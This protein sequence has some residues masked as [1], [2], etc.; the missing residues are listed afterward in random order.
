MADRIGCVPVRVSFPARRS[1]RAGGRKSIARSTTSISGGQAPCIGVSRHPSCAKLPQDHDLAKEFYQTQHFANVT[2]F[3]THGSGTTIGEAHKL[4]LTVI[5]RDINP[6]AVEAVRTALGPMEEDS[7]KPPFGPYRKA[8]RTNPRPLPIEGLEG[9]ALRRTLFL[10]GHAGAVLLMPHPRCCFPSWVIARNG[11]PSRKPE[12]QILC[13]SC[14]ASFRAF[15][16][17]RRDLPLMRHGLKSAWPSERSQGDSRARRRQVHD[18]GRGRFD[19]RA[20]PIQALRQ[21]CAHAAGPRIS[22][23]HTRRPGGIPGA[24]GKTPAGS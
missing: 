3:D 4:G 13:P 24:F 7:L 18:P 14:G 5:G 23:R 10:L 19:R 1:A 6:V 8:W 16:A 21:T 11:Y 9:F 2:E 15:M 20:S 22:T 17:R 12:V